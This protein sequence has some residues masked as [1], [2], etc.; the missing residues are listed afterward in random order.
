MINSTP[1]AL[2]K[3]CIIC[4]NSSQLSSSFTTEAYRT[5]YVKQATI[6]YDNVATQKH[7]CCKQD[8][9]STAVNTLS[10]LS[11]TQLDKKV[12]IFSW[13]PIAKTM[14]GLFILHFNHKHLPFQYAGNFNR[15]SQLVNT[16][17]LA[18]SCGEC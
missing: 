5:A 9:K 17:G 11:F 16:Y 15:L 18:Y 7:P 1:I 12:I 4:C 14:A 2:M 10:L 6:W 13:V 3:T 8:L